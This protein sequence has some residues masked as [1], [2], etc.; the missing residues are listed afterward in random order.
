MTVDQDRKTLLN[1]L[2]RNVQK[3][4][5]YNTKKEQIYE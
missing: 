3:H 2:Y 4:S 1:G 5:V